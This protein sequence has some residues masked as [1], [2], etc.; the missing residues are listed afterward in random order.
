[1]AHN[2][3]NTANSDKCV[4]NLSERLLWNFTV[5]H[6]PKERTCNQRN[7]PGD[8]QRKISHIQSAKDQTDGQNNK[9]IHTEETN[10][11]SKLEVSLENE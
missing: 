2:N 7:D 6:K 11:Q 3:P 10:F 9:I 4:D 1:M 8:N 5:D